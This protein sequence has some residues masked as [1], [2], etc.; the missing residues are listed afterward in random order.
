MNE[1]HLKMKIATLM[2]IANSYVFHKINRTKPLTLTLTINNS[3]NLNCRF[4]N[5]S[6]KFNHDEL[7]KGEIFQLL[8]EAKQLGIIYKYRWW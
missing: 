6:G 1:L 4:C 8:K 5:N 2:K 7:K 3:C